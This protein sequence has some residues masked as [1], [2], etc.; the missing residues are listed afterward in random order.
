LHPTAA[1][2]LTL[3]LMLLLMLLLTL[4]QGCHAPA[5]APSL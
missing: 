1:A 3:L 2:L 4:L 5:Y